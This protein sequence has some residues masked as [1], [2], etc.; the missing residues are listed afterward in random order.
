M[1]DLNYRIAKRLKES[2]KEKGLTQKELSKK[3]NISIQHLS[4]VECGKRRLTADL[5]RKLAEILEVVPEYLLCEIDFK[6]LQDQLRMDADYNIYMCDII[7]KF[8]N[9]MDVKVD[10][11]CSI[12]RQKRCRPI[13][14]YGNVYSCDW[15]CE[16]Q[17]GESCPAILEEVKL[18]GQGVA[19]FSSY[20]ESETD[21]VYLSQP[22]FSIFIG[23]ISEYISFMFHRYRNTLTGNRN[24]P[25]RQ[26]EYI[27]DASGNSTLYGDS[28]FIDE[29]IKSL[30]TKRCIKKFGDW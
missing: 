9:Y 7:V 5:A 15:I 29:G 21:T 23:N 17:D 28:L 1:E 8:F 26:R 24:V 12:E 10:F 4:Y 30:L 14:A 19:F 13:K 11:L 2:R 3:A 6:S 22:E 16:F 25:N 18:S 20:L 27:I